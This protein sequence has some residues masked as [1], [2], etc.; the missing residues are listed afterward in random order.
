MSRFVSNSDTDSYLLLRILL[1]EQTL[2]TIDLQIF[3]NL[4]IK[5]SV[6]FRI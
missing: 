5:N 2:S 6:L 3:L 4:K 1:P